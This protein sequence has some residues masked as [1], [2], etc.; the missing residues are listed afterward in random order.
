MEKEVKHKIP[1]TLSLLL[2]PPEKIEGRSYRV[3]PVDKRLFGRKRGWIESWN[4]ERDNLEVI[5][6]QNTG[7]TFSLRDFGKDQFTYSVSG[8]NS[9]EPG[10]K[11]RISHPELSRWKGAELWIEVTIRSFMEMVTV[12]R[13]IVSG[14]LAGTYCISFVESLHCVPMM[15]IKDQDEIVSKEAGRIL[16]Q[17]KKTKKL[18]PGHMYLQ[19]NLEKVLYLGQVKDQAYS[20]YGKSNKCYWDAFSAHSYSSIYPV[21]IPLY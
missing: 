4:N 1:Y 9:S 18:I 16:L 8:I 20:R 7:F 5:D 11:L 14:D 6:I 2:P 3:F 17:E 19:E 21:T 13:E 12:A 15:E 10:I